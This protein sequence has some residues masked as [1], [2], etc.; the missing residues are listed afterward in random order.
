[1]RYSLGDVHHQEVQHLLLTTFPSMWWFRR[2]LF[3]AALVFF[4]SSISLAMTFVPKTMIVYRQPG[5]LLVR[6]CAMAPSSNFVGSIYVALQFLGVRRTRLMKGW[7][8]STLFREVS[9]IRVYIAS[10]SLVKYRIKNH[11]DDDSGCVLW[12]NKSKDYRFLNTTHL[13]WPKHRVKS[14]RGVGNRCSGS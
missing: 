14:T 1:M 2:S 3:L 10:S 12:T 13:S 9:L 4:S 7:V 6:T 11:Q 8:G 5:I